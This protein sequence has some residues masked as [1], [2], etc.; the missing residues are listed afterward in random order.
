MRIKAGIWVSAYLRRLNAMAVPAVVARRGDAEAGAVFI[1]V[2][3]LDGAAQVF[4]PAASGAEGTEDERLF[5]P[6]FSAP[7]GDREAE[8]Y[9]AR[10]REFDP[11]LW[12]IEVEDK[13]GRHFLGEAVRAI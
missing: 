10:Q 2:N 9:L 4:R 13:E 12:V 8:A 11:D 7:R 5:A 3:T 6:A 1:K